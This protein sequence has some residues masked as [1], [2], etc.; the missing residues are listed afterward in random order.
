MGGAS[1]PLAGA[2][3]AYAPAFQRYAATGV[4]VLGR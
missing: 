3:P 1:L 2:L 4:I